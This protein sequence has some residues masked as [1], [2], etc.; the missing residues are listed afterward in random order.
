MPT[1]PQI[2]VLS[3]PL[4]GLNRSTG[5]DN[6]APETTPYCVNVRP[7]DVVNLSSAQMHGGRLRGGAR[8]GITKAYSQ[9]C[10]NGP[11]QMLN[12]ASSVT[13]TGGTNNILLAV[14]DGTLYENSTG[15]LTARGS[16]GSLN[17]TA[18]NLQG[19]QVGEKFYIADYRAKNL[20]GL[21]G[22]ITNNNRLSIPGGALI[23]GVTSEWNALSPAI[24]TSKDVVWISGSIDTESNI[25]PI[26][27]V[28]SG[29]IVFSGSMT[30]QTS[31]V[32]WQ[33]GRVPKVY[34]T[35]SPTTAVTSLMGTLPIPASNYKTGTVTV[36]S[37]IVTLAGSGAS[38]A[39]PNIP[40]AVASDPATYMLTLKIP[41]A[42]GIGT[43]SYLV[44]KKDSNTQMTLI[45]CT[46]DA[47]MP[48][49]TTY[50]LSWTSDYYGIPPLNCPLCCTYRGRLVLA[51]PGAVWYM[52]RVLDPN[53]WDYGYDPS[54]ASRAIGGTSTT[55]GGIPEPILALMPH[56]DQYLIFGCERSLWLLTSD[57][58]Y[59]GT[60]QALSRDVG[61][62]GPNAWCN[63]PDGSIVFLS[64]DGLYQIPPGASSYP[65]SISRQFL[66][67]ELLD[68]DWITNTISLC[69]DV[70]GRG[71][72]L[73][74]TP[75]SGATGIHFFVDWTTKSFWPVTLPNSQQPTIM[76]RYSP[77]S[78]FPA[79][80][81][82]GSYDGYTRKYSTSATTDDG[83]AFSSVICY[84]PIAIGGISNYGELVYLSAD[85]DSNGQSVSWGIYTGDN[86][87]EAIAS[88]VSG[89]T[90][91]NAEWT[92]T[93]VAG[94]N[95]RQY[96]RA[97][98]AAHVIM[99]SGTHG[100]AIEGLQIEGR[101]KRPKR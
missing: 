58:A 88:A 38:W 86:G 12:Y 2:K 55:T 37:G 59:G 24:D 99:V 81:I 44:S 23:D 8:P 98:G 47:D 56:S 9:Q 50:E 91:G 34:D 54:D 46:T 64:R 66:P 35:S 39:D 53:D 57:P 89:A 63:L 67:A 29:Y 11:I 14:A 90:A 75:V 68:V 95:Q 62:L 31:G 85:T 96:P 27:A 10:S 1:A 92:G 76:V 73:S 36:A 30:N 45:D 33:I 69:Y 70:W 26:T 20:K 83:T 49:G 84:G 65:Q 43:Q 13:S 32:V 40:T 48:S 72:H 93:F 97:F 77:N 74:I 4:G 79:S 22:V 71:I 80:V 101:Q 51:G 21:N 78:T 3:F 61:V 87:Q 15:S 19:T 42:S 52:S 41:N 25:Y 17:D 94:D 5:F 6:T 28:T 16:V 7:Y 60:I 82:L 18:P 100:W